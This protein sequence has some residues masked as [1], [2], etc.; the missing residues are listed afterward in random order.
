MNLKKVCLLGGMG[1]AWSILSIA[2]L[3]IR[4]E[5]KKKQWK[6]LPERFDS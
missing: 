2:G 5:K 6:L 4:Q 3:F 1:Y